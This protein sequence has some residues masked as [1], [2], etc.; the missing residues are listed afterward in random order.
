[1]RPAVV[2]AAAVCA[3]RL[4]SGDP[5]LRQ[6]HRRRDE[7]GA[8][9]G[10]AARH[11]REDG[12]LHRADQLRLRHAVD[13]HRLPLHPR[14]RLRPDPRRRR[15]GAEPR[16]A[17]VAAAG[18]ALVCRAGGRPRHRRQ[19]HGGAE[20]EAVLSQADHRARARADRSDHRTQYGPD[21]RSGR[22]SLRHQ[23]RAVGCLCRRKP[24]AAGECA[25]T[26]LAQ[27]RGRNRVCPRRQV[28]RP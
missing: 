7:P 10:A 9:R 1:M 2:G 17:G 23:P 6:R 26:G 18:R 25:I 15:R 11:G 21:R 19:D 13:R 27:G 4:R 20:A 12:R 8:G 3:D 5:G 16:A 28:L 22:P 14:R 24:Q